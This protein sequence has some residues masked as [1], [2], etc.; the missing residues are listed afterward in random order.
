MLHIE[1]NGANSKNALNQELYKV[2]NK[3]IRNKDIDKGNETLRDLGFSDRGI[4][5]LRKPDF[6]GRVGF[7][8]YVLQNNNANIHRIE[9]RIKSLQATKEVGTQ[10]KGYDSLKVVENTDMM[11]LQIL[12]DGKPTSDVRDILKHNGF[13]WAPSQSAWQR[14][15]TNNAKYALKGVLEQLNGMEFIIEG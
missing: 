2:A 15:L 7:P 13:R 8:D 9:D 11:R 5:E 6:C 10:E 1:I 12:F 3:A 4:E 14:Q